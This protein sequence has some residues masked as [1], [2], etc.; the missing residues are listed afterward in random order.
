M[1]IR[2]FLYLGAVFTLLAM[3]SMVWHAARAIEHVWPWWAFGI[4]MGI[5][6]LT[7]LA[8]FEKNRPQVQALVRATR[9]FFYGR[10]D[11]RTQAHAATADTQSSKRAELGFGAGLDDLDL[12][13]L[14]AGL[15]SVTA[16]VL[17]VG[18][19]RDA[20]TGVASVATVAA[21]FPTASQV[22]IDGAGHFP[23]VDEASAFQAAVAGFLEG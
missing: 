23:W 11:D 9:P 22:V 6:I 7:L 21:D 2:A 1:R 19:S 8:L 14:R 16:P 18:G 12:D 3:V 20:L 4:G 5:A 10:W 13:A 17:V 15:R